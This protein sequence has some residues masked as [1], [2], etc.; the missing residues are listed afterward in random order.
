MRKKAFATP[1]AS[2]SYDA[3]GMTHTQAFQCQGI[4]PP[5]RRNNTLPLY[6]FTAEPGVSASEG[7]L[8]AHS[9]LSCMSLDLSLILPLRDGRVR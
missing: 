9:Q 3:K 7:G 8:E 6:S 1:P 2:Q 4:S 5:F